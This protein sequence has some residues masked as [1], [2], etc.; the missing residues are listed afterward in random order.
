M[1]YPPSSNP[2]QT[3][4]PEV[5]FHRV[6]RFGDV[7]VGY[8]GRTDL[9]LRMIGFPNPSDPSAESIVDYSSVDLIVNNDGTER[10]GL[11][12]STEYPELKQDIIRTVSL[13]EVLALWESSHGKPSDEIR[14]LIKG[15]AAESDTFFEQYPQYR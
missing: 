13:D 15:Y 6:P 8:K 1:E 11:P 12:G 10:I 14:D 4:N 2:D 5:L 9:V 7:L 3:P